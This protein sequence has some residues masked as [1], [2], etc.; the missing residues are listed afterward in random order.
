MYIYSFIIP[1]ASHTLYYFFFQL[2][3]EPEFEN[4]GDAFGDEGNFVK[5]NQL[6]SIV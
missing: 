1:T 3:A 2:A 6:M 4:F 5:V